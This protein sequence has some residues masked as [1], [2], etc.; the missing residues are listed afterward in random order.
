MNCILTVVLSASL[1]SS[2]S[3]P[4][5][6]VSNQLDAVG[7]TPCS[8]WNMDDC[9]EYEATTTSPP[10]TTTYPNPETTTYP[11]PQTTTYPS[12]Y[13]H[14][15]N[16]LLA[17]DNVHHSSQWRHKDKDNRILGFSNPQT[18]TYPHPPTTTYPQSEAQSLKNKVFESD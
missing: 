2:D 15:D 8:D 9:P 12:P 6:G 10:E 11:P 13:P 7:D 18:T 14:K 3:E 4:T 17:F 16:R 5:A 1:V